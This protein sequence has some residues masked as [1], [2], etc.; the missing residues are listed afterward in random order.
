MRQ[1]WSEANK[2]RIWRQIWAALAE[3]EFDFGLVSA[4]QVDDLR[5]HADQVDIKRALEIEAEIH[6]D[7]MAEIKTFAEQAPVGGAILHL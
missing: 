1:I 7:L 5:R 2:R 4:E 3:T 6:H